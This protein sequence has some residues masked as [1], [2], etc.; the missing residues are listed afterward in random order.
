MLLG[1]RDYETIRNYCYLRTCMMKQQAKRQLHFV[2]AQQASK[3]QAVE[4]AAQLKHRLVLRT[5]FWC[6]LNEK[7]ET[8]PTARAAS[9]LLLTR[10]TA[11]RA[12]RPIQSMQHAGSEGP[13][14]LQSSSSRKLE[15]LLW[16]RPGRPML[17][18]PSPQKKRPASP[19][20]TAQRF[21]SW[22]GLR[23]AS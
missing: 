13:P 3:H 21:F 7:T 6:C 2:S 11:N 9:L 10:L 14:L 20:T 22:A 18:L 1:G 12:K 5:L 8:N 17:S 19:L 23:F 16:K 15:Q 4:E